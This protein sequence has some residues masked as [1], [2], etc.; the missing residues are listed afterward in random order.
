MTPFQVIFS[1]RIISLVRINHS[2]RMALFA[3]SD[4]VIN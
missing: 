2:D 1:R 4:N 3:I